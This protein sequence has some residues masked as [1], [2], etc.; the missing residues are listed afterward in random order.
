MYLGGVFSIFRST[1]LVSIGFVPCSCAYRPPG[2]PLASLRSHGCLLE[3][4]N[5]VAPPPLPQDATIEGSRS[6]GVQGWGGGAPGT[7]PLNPNAGKARGAGRTGGG[8]GGA[9]GA[10]STG[11]RKANT[12]KTSESSVGTIAIMGGGASKMH[13]DGPEWVGEESES[14]MDAR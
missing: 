11:A 14:P 1:Q 2:S 3:T 6:N 9:G 13:I 10:G 4:E 8:G 12:G 5:T 7:T